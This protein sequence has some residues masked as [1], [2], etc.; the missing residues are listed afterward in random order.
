M[1]L[2]KGCANIYLKGKTLKE[3]CSMARCDFCFQAKALLEQPV[4]KIKA[5][6]C[7]ACNYKIQQVV[8]FLEHSGV[9]IYVQPELQP[10]EI[11]PPT[12]PVKRK[13]PTKVPKSTKKASKVPDQPPSRETDL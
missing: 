5:R 12:P 1:T 13:S 4:P 8:G 10:E 2:I 11:S 7:K 9:G 3:R 6:V